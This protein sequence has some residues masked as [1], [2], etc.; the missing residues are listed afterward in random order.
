VFRPAPRCPQC[1]HV[2][3]VQVRE[4]EQVEGTL[5]EVVKVQQIAKRREVG[6]AQTLE[7]LQ[8]IGR[9]RGYA[10]GWAYNMWRARQS[11]RAA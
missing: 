8:E 4:I 2:P 11:R 10:S 6:R 7:E 3:P 9:Q 1:G 5:Q